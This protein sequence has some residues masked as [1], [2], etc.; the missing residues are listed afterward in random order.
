[1]AN[2][3]KALGSYLADDT[4][5]DEALN[6]VADPYADRV[7]RIQ[8]SGQSSPELQAFLARTDA[9]QEQRDAERAVEAASRL[10]QVKAREDMPQEGVPP[11]LRRTEGMEPRVSSVSAPSNT[12]L[13]SFLR[14]LAASRPSSE[15]QPSRQPR[16]SDLGVVPVPPPEEASAELLGPCFR[17]VNESN[18]PPQDIRLPV[19]PSPTMAVAAPRA[20]PPTPKPASVTASIPVASAPVRADVPGAVKETVAPI[21]P[22][23]EAEH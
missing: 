22:P 5:S 16:G 20:S 4:L 2:G 10:P 11:L 19:E 3:L 17:P 14:Q 21:T 12:G 9:T 23:D 18:L 13:N 15:A 6:F 1:M 8:R 7:T